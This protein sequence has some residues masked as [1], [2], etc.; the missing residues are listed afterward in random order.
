MLPSLCSHSPRM[1]RAKRP[2]RG[3]SSAPSTG[4]E[5][6]QLEQSF[7]PGT[8]DVMAM[9]VWATLHVTPPLGPLERVQVSWKWPVSL[10]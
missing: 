9:S 5:G 4:P 1:S 2:L 3:P 8:R 10:R 7:L 6:D